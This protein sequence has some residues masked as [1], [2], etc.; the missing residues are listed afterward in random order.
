MKPS[1]RDSLVV[2]PTPA[3]LSAD[4]P[5][6]HRFERLDAV[7]TLVPGYYWRLKK[8]HEI[9]DQR[10]SGPSEHKIKYRAGTVHLLLDVFEFDGTVHSV[11][12][13]EDPARDP[14]VQ[15]ADR[16]VPGLL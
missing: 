14:R 5:D 15:A 1:A 16:R 7:E 10:F 8:D 13:L 12:L 11:T 3:S 6:E 9:P 2:Q 4:S